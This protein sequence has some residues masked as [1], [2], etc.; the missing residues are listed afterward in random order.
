MLTSFRGHRWIGRKHAS[1]HGYSR[2]RKSTMKIVLLLFLCN[3]LSVKHDVR[4]HAPS[5]GDEA[6][7]YARKIEANIR[8]IAT[9]SA[10][11]DILTRQTVTKFLNPDARRAGADHFDA[12][13]NSPAISYSEAIA[14]FDA[15]FRSHR[16]ASEYDCIARCYLEPNFSDPKPLTSTYVGGKRQIVLAHDAFFS[17]NIIKPEFAPP[18]S[19]RRTT[20]IRYPKDRI[21]EYGVHISNITVPAE[22]FRANGWF[23]YEYLTWQEASIVTSGADGNQPLVRLDL[24]DG[25]KIEITLSPKYGFNP[26]KFVM[27]YGTSK[28]VQTWD[29]REIRGSFVPVFLLFEQFVDGERKA[30]RRYRARIE[31]IEINHSI[32]PVTFTESYFNLQDYDRFT[33]S[34]TRENFEILNGEKVEVSPM[35]DGRQSLPQKRGRT[36]WFVLLGLALG[37]TL[38]TTA[39]IARKS[40]N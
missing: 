13:T 38:I 11:Y 3:L 4:A 33:N 15:D 31:T 30:E 12:I 34:V 19:H 17:A 18:G 14:C 23:L 6:K 1:R 27:D 37:I 29:Y 32:D 36:R 10:T 28:F 40:G 21:N 39:L 5:T 2:L 26:I 7:F 35:V 24:P 25:S 8:S 22:F 20:L 16:F 9:F